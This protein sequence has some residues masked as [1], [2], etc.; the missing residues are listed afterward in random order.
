[1]IVAEI[2]VLMMLG[3]TTWLAQNRTAGHR[4]AP[5]DRLTAAALILTAAVTV[6]AVAAA[7]VIR[8]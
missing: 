5:N 2:V 3:A 4:G 6:A 7:L 1:M 8:P